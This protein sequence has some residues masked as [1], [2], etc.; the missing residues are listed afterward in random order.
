MASFFSQKFCNL[1]YNTVT[2]IQ[3][4]INF[5]KKNWNYTKKSTYTKHVYNFKTVYI[6]VLTLPLIG[7][8]VDIFVQNVE[9]KAADKSNG[10]LVCAKIKRN[11]FC[12]FPLLNCFDGKLKCFNSATGCL[13][14][15]H[16]FHILIWQLWLV[17]LRYVM[18]YVTCVTKC[19]V[20]KI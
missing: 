2:L 12:L 11:I 9:V 13:S 4:L 5:H 6:T 7:R 16:A 19:V 3:F 10:F 18:W 1:R 15:A 14:F 20:F 17:E 8:P